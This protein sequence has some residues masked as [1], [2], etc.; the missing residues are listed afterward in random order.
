MV[1]HYMDNETLIRLSTYT[2]NWPEPKKTEFFGFIKSDKY[3]D[4]DPSAIDELTKLEDF[5]ETRNDWYTKEEKEKKKKGGKR[6]PKVQTEEGSSSQPQKKRK[7]KAFET[8]LVDE[9]K[10]DETEANVEEDHEPLSLETDQLMK[11]IDDT[12]EAG[13]SASKVVVDDEEKSLY[14]SEDDIDAQV[15]RWISENYG[16][17]EREREQQKKRKR[18]TDDDDETYVPPE[19][20]QVVSPPSSGGRKK[21]TSRKRVI[22]PAS[23]KLKFTFKINPP[24]EPQSKPPSPPPQN[25]PP[26]PPPQQASPEHVQSPQSSPQQHTSLPIHEQTQITSP[27]IQQTP[28]VHSTPGSSGF[29][30]FPPIL[31]DITLE[32]LDDFSFMNDDLV[33]KLQK[34]V[35]EVSNEKKKLEKRVKSV[36]SENSSLLK[37][38]E[39]D[40]VDVDILKVRVAD[41]EEEKS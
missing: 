33:K 24:T 36:E 23:R 17:R 2:K 29:A 26:S 14:G 37:R 32:K 34:K 9:P 28:P 30:N 8:M 31:D 13:K 27:H 22:T 3:E 35:D 4:P 21:S 11:D 19:N 40:Q 18:S 39:T 38:I 25:K 6:T 10:E 12:F 41:L 16:P 20:A 1:L 7:K 5:V 15:E